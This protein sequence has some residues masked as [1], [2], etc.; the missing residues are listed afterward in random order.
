M[1]TRNATIAIINWVA[2]PEDRNAVTADCKPTQQGIA[3]IDGR[4][5]I[6]TYDFQGPGGA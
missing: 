5:V 2:N 1:I 3:I 6:K 4:K